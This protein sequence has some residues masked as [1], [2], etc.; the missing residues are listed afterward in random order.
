M[1][2]FTNLA[3]GG[4]GGYGFA[5]GYALHGGPPERHWAA[6]SRAV[7]MWG[8][9]VPILTLAF[10]SVIGWWSLLLLLV[11]PLQVV[12]LALRG[13]GRPTRESWWRAVSVVLCKFPEVLG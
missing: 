3:S 5:Q 2:R 9:C 6:E 12:R 1:P 8:L 11:Y 10:A 13:G 4:G 7:W